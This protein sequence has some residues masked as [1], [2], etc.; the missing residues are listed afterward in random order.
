MLNFSRAIY[1]VAVVSL[2]SCATHLAVQPQP[3]PLKSADH[4]QQSSLQYIDS[5]VMDL[6][7]YLPPP[8]T[9]DSELANADLDQV[10]LIQKSR[11]PL[12]VESAQAD[13]QENIWRFAS[14]VG[15]ARFRSENLPI[16]TKFF[17]RVIA[18]ERL[19]AESA[20]AKWNRQRPFL[21][22]AKVNPVVTRP[23]SSSYPSGHATVGTVMGI[24]LGEMIPEKRDKILARALEFANNRVIGGVHFPS[25]VVAGRISGSLIASALMSRI[26]FKRDFSAA[27]DELRSVLS[28]SF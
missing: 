11:T 2:T 1:A 6:K 19:L 26:D 14:V 24:V 7:N 25:D 27:K 16:F 23:L 10:L 8:P 12:Q 9:P 21:V 20:K 3:H 15:N 13:A 22:S 28:D 5:T 18:T 4:T 17:E